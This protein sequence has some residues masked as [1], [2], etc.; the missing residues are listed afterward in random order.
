VPGKLSG[1]QQ[2]YNP[3]KSYTRREE[4]EAKAGI[5]LTEPVYVKYTYFYPIDY[6]E[7]PGRIGRG[8]MATLREE[9][10]HTLR[11]DI[12]TGD[13]EPGKVLSEQNIADSLDVSRTPVREALARLRNDGL[14]K[15]VPQKGMSVRE[16]TI[17]DFV[18]I[19]TILRALQQFA[20]G[21]LI[22][23]GDPIDLTEIRRLHREERATVSDPWKSFELNIELHSAI[24]D[25]ISN[26]RM[27]AM[28]RNMSDQIMLAGYMSS[29]WDFE[30]ALEQVY[31]E[32]E[33]II[34]ALEN[35]DQ[36]AFEQAL[37]E[38]DENALQRMLR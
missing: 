35:R 27:T 8:Q 18:E 16:M 13:I 1:P 38:H 28:A 3:K 37:R 24:I 10:Y 12:I 4:V 21:E 7:N 30:N 25:L 15:Y 23:R 32:H 14:L 19:S 2:E 22:R 29:S 36:A 33:A 5:L 26:K 11:R 31:E 20:V 17:R 9:V 6:C 34:R